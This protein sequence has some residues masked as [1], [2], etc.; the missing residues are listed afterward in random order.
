MF[1]TESLDGKEVYKQACDFLSRLHCDLQTLTF[2]FPNQVFFYGDEGIGI[3][4]DKQIAFITAESAEGL[5]YSEEEIKLKDCGGYNRLAN[6]DKTWQ[7]H[8][9]PDDL[10]KAVVSSSKKIRFA[11]DKFYE[12]IQTV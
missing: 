4:L 3:I 12:N 11:C 7:L 2:L 6:P 10:I 9:I 1:A 5:Y 8:E